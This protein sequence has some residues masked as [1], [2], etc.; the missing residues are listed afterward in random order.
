MKAPAKK[1]VAM[2]QERTQQITQ[3]QIDFLGWNAYEI[4]NGLIRLV[5]VPDIGG[6]IMAYDLGPHAYLYVDRT[7]AGKLFS[8]EENQGDGSLAAWKNYGGDKTWPAPQGWDHEDQWAGPPDS[9]LDTGQYH[10]DKCHSNAGEAVIQMTSPSGSPTGVQITRQATI[11]AG[12]SRVTLDLSFRNI[13]QRSVRWSIWDVV[14]LNAGRLNSTGQL[15]PE[16]E[17]VVTA[18]LNPKSKYESGYSVMFGDL[19]NPQWQVDH[20][21]RLFLGSY[22]WEIGKVG[23]DSRDGWAAFANKATRQAFAAR[24]TPQPEGEYP[25]GGAGV[26]FWTVG[27]GTVANLDYE[28]SDIYLME[29]EILSPFQ[30]IEPGQTASFQIE[31]G[32]CLCPGPIVDVT[33]GGCVGRKLMA[34]RQGQYTH[35]TGKFGVFDLGRLKLEWLD[36]DGK[37]LLSSDM[38]PVSPLGVVALDHILEGPSL[39]TGVQLTVAYDNKQACVLAGAGV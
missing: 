20:T 15:S 16:T 9:I 14:Q 4:S 2:T 22:Q 27:R 29:V 6:R 13:S 7:L 11:R 26:E 28:H 5:A 17:C 36:Q 31:W 19:N 30:K 23:L 35:I 1:G 24:Y 25:D 38:G 37:V 39:A 3:Q 33:E 21:N 32:S 12:S 18:P 8:A 34:T 10:L